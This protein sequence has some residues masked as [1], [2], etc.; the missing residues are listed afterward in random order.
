MKK[1]LQYVQWL[2]FWLSACLP[3]AITAAATTAAAATAAAPL[4]PVQ[5]F[6]FTEPE[7]ETLHDAE[8]IDNQAIT[9]L[10]QD[11]RGL[12]WIGTQSGLVR[13]DGYRFRKFSHIG[14]NPFS[15][16]GDFV[17]A[18]SIA[19]DGRIWVGTINDGVSVF[20][21]A[22]ERFEHFRHDEKVPDSL[23]A[24][25][26]SALVDDGRGGMWIATEQGLDHLPAGSSRFVHFRHGTDPHRLM[27]DKVRSLLLDK[28]G[29]L[30]VGSSS[31]L[32]RL[33]PD[34]KSFVTVVTGRN[35][36]TL[37]QAQDGKLWLGTREHGA[38]WLDASPSGGMPPN[39]PQQAHW[40]PLAQLS[41]P[42]IFGIAQVKADQILLATFG[43]GIIV[44]AASNGNVLQTLRRDP[45][46]AGSL[47]L[48]E[49]KP[50]LLDRAGWLWVGTWGG[51]LQRMN[52]N[53]TML[54]VL[55]HSAKRPNGLS[56]PDVRSVL[57]LADGRL[58]IGNNGNGID[59]FD[60][61][62]GLIGG[63]RTS[64]GQ[65][66]ALPDATILALAQT[67]DGSIWAGTQQN[68]VVRQLAGSTAWVTVPGLPGKEVNKLLASRN[69]SLWAGTDRGVAHW[70]PGEPTPAHFEALAD[71][72]GKPMQVAVIALAEDKH[73]RIWIGT[74][75]GLWLHEPGHNGLI[76]IPAEPKRPDGLVSDSISCLLIDSHDRLWI[77]TDKGLERLTSRDSKLAR[78]EHVSALFDQAGKAL[79]GN[80]L[81]D[82][83]GRIWTE[84]GVIDLTTDGRA[85]NRP[86]NIRMN[87][88]TP[89]EGM[90]LGSTWLGSYAQTR[91]GL[92]LFGGVRGVAII[93]PARFKAYDYTPPLIITELKING[94]A[95]A[96][97]IL[98]T[99]HEQTGSGTASS[100]TLKP[101]QRNF[102]FEFAA[103]DYSE[104]KK[105]RY[106]YRL[107]GY[108]KNWIN[109]DA[110]HRN[111]AY[112]NLWPG[113]YTLQVRGSNRLGDW[114]PH[115]LR[116][117]IQI[118]P[119]WWQTW[120]F[121]I[122]LLLSMTAFIAAL[123]QTRTRYLRQR[124]H[125]LEQLIDERTSELRQKQVELVDSNQ[126]LNNA[127]EALN[128][129]NAG[130]ALSVETLRQLGD[131][132]REI[133]ANLDADIV[134]KSLYLY[135]GGLLDAPTMTIYRM[136]PAATILNAV[137][138]REND[139]VVAIGNETLDSTTSNAAR[140]ARERQELLLHIDPLTDS[141]YHVSGT[142][143]MLTALFAPLIVDD[144]VLGVMS[145]QSDKQN[146]YGERERLIFRTL[147]A[148][149]AIAL[150]N[151]GAIAA[152]SKAQGQ[153]VQQEKM[154]SLGGLVAGIAH[155]INTPLGNT[156]VA[157]SGAEVA[158]QTLQNAIAS[159][160][161][162]QSILE[163]S[164]ADGI[165]YTAL[166]LKTAT[167]AAELIALFKTISV[168][169]ASDRPIEVELAS[170]LQEVATLVR[171]QLAQNDCKLELEVPA[172]LSIYV[173]ADAL[174]E[175]LSRVL[176]NVLN[177]AFTNGRTGTLHLHAQADEGDGVVISVSDNGH[178]IA[179]ED[180]P[181]V[182]DPF[183]TT[184]SGMHGHVGL[185]LHVAYNHVTE[186]LKG[187]INI[188][189]TQGEGTCV[190]IRLKEI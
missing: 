157:I 153:L 136:N 130:L 29:R 117:P 129:S 42:Y 27:D 64:Q 11:A 68:G 124:Q 10:A 66:G 154:A 37:F 63:Y 7:F 45:A 1:N 164:T 127:N 69:G 177:H 179:P 113:S 182:F 74:Q 152:L 76:A 178:G 134:F 36:L 181:K 88:L 95:V 43:G 14:S 20:N 4:S 82:R 149:G 62:R 162:S 145:I 28:R 138:G 159:G 158:W 67:N 6:L 48:D 110:D 50:L 81:E 58:L 143:K 109:T 105:T 156:L 114:S 115:E 53:N 35:V 55:R 24:G 185:G 140:A 34:G 132:G 170:Y 183:F 80:L 9:A 166:A 128:E 107:Q 102:T 40:L 151:A 60:R 167:R 99:T 92:L 79:G 188:T 131:I 144:R 187:K 106:Q 5:D 23:G 94:E 133:T 77:S 56:H 120:W 25:T 189:S 93:D 150:A 108:E 38:A 184:K 65:I 73:G 97:G 83:Q 16:A 135:V 172:G 176:V 59:I 12:I 118:L 90:D 101:T 3:F 51:G 126:E 39:A 171:S 46:L 47:A 18:L 44:V 125:E 21:P 54:R 104:P 147:S 174:T 61:Q 100:L 85:A 33:S 72:R 137:F 148:Y 161:V 180:L 155:E 111:A 87:R 186:R 30:W 89:A 146:A 173:V 71:E 41:N 116:I 139:Q 142:R 22:S 169:A 17:N 57:E 19:K 84:E 52:A 168:D 13:Y 49:I 8:T 31:G 78:F 141:P 96:P 165:E 163:S 2:V 121:G 175:T 70:R 160:R 190:E 32:Q 122:V 86:T 26:I 119:A 15:L 91:D 98:A 103:L 112:G 75:N 123:V